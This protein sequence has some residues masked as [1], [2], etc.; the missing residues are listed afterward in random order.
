MQTQLLQ[1]RIALVTGAGRGVGEGIAR[2]LHDA[3]ATVIV[4]EFDTATGQA[5]A[6]SLARAQFIP[7]DVGSR[8][9]VVGAINEVQATYGRLDILVN[10]AYPTGA[11][12]SRLENRSDDDFTRA[13]EAGFMGPWWAM[14]AAFPGMRD[15]RWGRVINVCSLNGVNAHPYT[16]EY[17]TAK[18]ALRA[19]SRTAAREW[20][21]HGIC[22]NV[23]CP[24]ARTAAFEMF[25][26][27]SPDNA[28]LMLQQNPM[29]R[30]GDPEQD[31]GGVALFLA[32]EDARYVT[33]NTLHAD[34]GGHINGVNWEPPVA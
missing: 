2:R 11:V 19:L 17:N 21:R 26:K 8:E 27:H 20:A 7:V 25:E 12:P 6:D 28:A 29:G 16:A 30:M 23:I 5:T 1:D 24:A 13:H 22:V 34:G 33:G 9:Q 10:N 14:Q 4:A 18:E 3:G 31:I 32:S 15:R